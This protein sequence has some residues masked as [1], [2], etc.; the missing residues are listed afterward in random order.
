MNRTLA[1]SFHKRRVLI[2]A[3]SKDAPSAAEWDEYVASARQWRCDIRALLVLSD[4]GGPNASQRAALDEA[5]G[6]ENHTAKTAVVTVS[7]MARG[8]V[9]A[10]GWFSKGIKAF[11]TNQIS[12]ALDYLEIP[13]ADQDAVLVEVKRVRER[14][15]MPA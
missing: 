2:L 4:G 14:L 8:I 13:K 10:I 12:A 6:L 11:S 5:L 9:T 1:F 3:H 15:N 7:M